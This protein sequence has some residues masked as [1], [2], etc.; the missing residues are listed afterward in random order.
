VVERADAAARL[1]RER[2]GHGRRQGVVEDGQVAV[3]RAGL[4]EP[5]DVAGKPLVDRQRVDVGEVTHSAD[6]VPDAARAVADGVALVRRR[7]PLVDDHRLSRDTPA[8][9]GTGSAW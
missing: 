4:A 5:P 8:P 9:S 7:H 6:Q 3:V 2:G 1:G